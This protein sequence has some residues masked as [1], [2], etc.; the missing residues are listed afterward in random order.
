MNAETTA[1]R[2]RLAAAGLL[3]LLPVLLRLLPIGHGLPQNH[4]PD[5][6][7]VRAALGMAKDR[8]LAP[9]VGR[10]STYPNLL[11]YVLLPVYAGQ[12]AL[13]RASGAWAGSGEYANHVLAEP[14]SV[15]RP[16]RITLA[17]LSALA[18]W[19][20]F[21]GARTMGLG[22]GAWIAAWLV[23]TGL[24]HL[25]FSV[26]ERPWGPL[27]TILALGLWAAARHVRSG[28]RRDLLACAA[29]LGLAAATHQAGLPFLGVAGLAWIAGPARFT[30]APDLRRRVAQ[31]ALAVAVFVGVALLVGYPQRLLHGATPTEQVAG[32][33]PSGEA[34]QA[35]VELGGQGLVLD[36]RLASLERLSA[37]FWSYDPLLVALGGL[38]LLLTARR[39]V[40]WPACG[41]ALAWGAFFG[42]NQNDHVRYLLPLAVL[43][44]YPAGAA[45]ERIWRAGA[46]ARLLLIAALALPLVQAVRFVHL[47]RQEDTRSL[48]VQAL[49]QLPPQSVVAIDRYGPQVPLSRAALE[50]LAELRP[51]TRREEFRLALLTAR[52][53]GHAV[54]VPGGEGLDVVPLEDLVRFD[55]RHR[56]SELVPAA[57][58]LGADLDQVL[59]ALGVTHLLLVDRDPGDGLPPLLVDPAP[60]LP[61]E[62]GPQAGQLAPRLPPLRGLGPALWTIRPGAA[63]RG[64]ARLPTEV[65]RAWR[66]LWQVERPGPELELRSFPGT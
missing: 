47:L 37:A 63:G 58:A 65:D 8:D 34:P 56:G 32:H 9:P 4:V 6:H 57:A 39:R 20:V 2:A 3:L 5:T 19:L 66:T 14:Q 25:Q 59:A 15:H 21:R 23:T 51:L 53:E 33:D 17:L 48:A 12:Y 43:L 27:V 46:G 7:V 10:Y 44:A 62:R 49:A 18:P 29:A 31:G 11:P 45:A 36:L 52:A 28:A 16:A 50:R 38:G 41:L 35:D 1:P 24:L 13:G 64:E 61:L 30:T 22:V 42:T 54:E 55:E 26:Q 60:A 40:Y